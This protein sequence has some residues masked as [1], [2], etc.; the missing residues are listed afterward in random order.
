M[1]HPAVWAL[2][3]AAPAFD[4][5]SRERIAVELASMQA[6]TPG[7]LALT[8]CHRVE[9]YG[10]GPPPAWGGATVGRAAP[11]PRVLVAEHAVRHACRLAAGLESTV[12]GEGQVLHQMRQAMRNRDATF[13]SSVIRTWQAA[14]WCGRR[15]RA[16][17]AVRGRDLATVAI[18]WLDTHLEGLAGRTVLVAGTGVM[19]R[20][21]AEAARAAGAA[22]TLATWTPARFR[23]GNGVL[24]LDEAASL[25]PTFDAV[26]VAL[27]GPWSDLAG[28]PRL[29]L[30]VDL[31]FP[32]AVPAVALS[33]AVRFADVDA[34]AAINGSLTLADGDGAEAAYRRRA[35]RTVDEAVARVLAWLA[36]R[37]ST[38]ALRGLRETAEAER[39]RAVERL[40]RRLPDLNARERELVQTL[41]RQLV[42]AVLHRPTAALASDIDGSAAQAADRLFGR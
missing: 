8:T 3:A 28:V 7:S 14:L 21:L 30:V 26:A 12:V 10:S 39:R 38:P 9:L 36:A 11:S 27:R 31:S 20:G 15:A 22:T 34:L 29:P 35:E 2:T 32:S 5:A 19:G 1:T 6:R 16:G 33:V 24:S 37:P 42:A 23:S 40:I 41:S 25:A 13:D 17:A 4:A 18:G